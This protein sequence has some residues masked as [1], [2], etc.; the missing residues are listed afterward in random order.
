MN[1]T[2]VRF[3]HIRLTLLFTAI[4]FF[5]L[6]F[7]MSLLFLG[8]HLLARFGLIGEK[9]FH[10]F[11]FC[12]SSIVLGTLLATIFSPKALQYIHEIIAA[13][14]KIADGD[15]SARLSLKGPE[16]FRILADRFNH[17]ATELGSVEMLRIDF[18]NNFSHEFKTPIVSIRGFAKALKWE[19]LSVEERNEYLDIIISESE[20]LSEL[21]S[22]VLYLSKLENQSI[23]T[24]KKRFNVTEQIRLVLALLDEK[25]QQKKIDLTFDNPE[26]FLEGNEEM[27]RQV[28]VNL[29]D[30]ALKFSPDGSQIEIQIEEA[31][32]Q[33]T[34]RISNDTTPISPEMKEHLFDKFY[35]GDPSH[36]TPGNG[37]G[38]SI[39]KKIITLHE[40][41]I[42]ILSAEQRCIFEILLPLKCSIHNATPQ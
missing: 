3:R 41:S 14:D 21:S 1:N 39:V 5:I 4:V 29:L 2:K 16:E 32:S 26:V 34:I 13:T 33:L 11:L 19:D 18:V 28:W 35:Q 8:T 38:L 7:T 36:S 17:M 24:D 30:N 9:P 23:L 12:L 25:I 10:L 20:R 6:L 27:M 37:L 42:D 15:Y 40:G 31:P 22:N